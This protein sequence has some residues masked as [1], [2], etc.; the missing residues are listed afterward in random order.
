MGHQLH[1]AVFC[2]S[3]LPGAQVQAYIWPIE[4]Q[5]LGQRGLR[6]CPDWKHI[7]VQ[8]MFIDIGMLL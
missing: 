4:L 1:S 6:F 5:T 7:G 8:S 3:F 2:G